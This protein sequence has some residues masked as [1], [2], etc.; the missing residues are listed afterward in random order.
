MNYGF[1]EAVVAHNVHKPCEWSKLLITKE[2]AINEPRKS[3]TSQQNSL[4]EVLT[5][6]SFTCWGKKTCWVNVDMYT[7]IIVTF[8]FDVRFKVC[9]DK[10]T[11]KKYVNICRQL[12]LKRTIT[13]NAIIYA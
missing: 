13:L 9:L 5:F 7:L 8:I 6:I 11:F 4:S 10:D 12:D 3:D 2:V 1:G